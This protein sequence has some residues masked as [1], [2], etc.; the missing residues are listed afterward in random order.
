MASHGNIDVDL[1]IDLDE[2][3][4]DMSPKFDDY[5]IQFEEKK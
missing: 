5:E 4:F 1:S 3:L 2:N